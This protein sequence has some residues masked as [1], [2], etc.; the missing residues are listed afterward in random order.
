MTTEQTLLEK[1]KHDSWG[2][3]GDE[4]F[5]YHSLAD[6]IDDVIAKEVDDNEYD[7]EAQVND[8]FG[9]AGADAHYSHLSSV[10]SHASDAEDYLCACT[11][12]EGT[13]AEIMSY[14]KDTFVHCI[15]DR[16]FE[17]YQEGNEDWTAEYRLRDKISKTVGRVFYRAAK[18]FQRAELEENETKAKRAARKFKRRF[19]RAVRH[20]P[21]ERDYWLW[22]SKEYNVTIVGGIVTDVRMTH[23]Y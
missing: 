12:D 1:Y 23:E 13:T 17:W 3:A 16:F 9:V 21:K 14:A 15:E 20:L 22:N 10:I 4:V 5:Y 18:E 7:S 11:Q 6:L 8:I 2:M 19:N